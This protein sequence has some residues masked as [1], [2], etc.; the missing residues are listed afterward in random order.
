MEINLNIFGEFLG[1]KGQDFIVY[2]DGKP[3]QK[4]P[5]HKVKRAV[6]SSGNCV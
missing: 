4:I 6:I 3:S 1:V 5:F 2:H